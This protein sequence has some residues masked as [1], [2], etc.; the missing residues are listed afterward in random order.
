MKINLLWDAGTPESIFALGSA[1]EDFSW[2]RFG[3]VRVPATLVGATGS[4]LISTINQAANSTF[5]LLLY[6]RKNVPQN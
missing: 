4:I 5:A 1:P 6:L 3:G 2:V